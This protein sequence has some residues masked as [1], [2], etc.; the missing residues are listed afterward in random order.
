L[1]AKGLRH[2]FTTE[3]RNQ[4]G[5]SIDMALLEGPFRRFSAQWRFTRLSAEAAKVEFV[6]QYEF[7]SRVVAAVL[8]PVFSRLADSTVDAFTRRATGRVHG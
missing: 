1:S 5:K 2:A 8:D 3:N 7:A 4:P 6:L